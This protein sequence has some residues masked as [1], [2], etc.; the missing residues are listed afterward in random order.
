MSASRPRE[1]TAVMV[2]GN[3]KQSLRLAP[4]IAQPTGMPLRSVA[5]DHFQPHLPRSRRC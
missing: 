3:S 1:A 4:A 2:G 5:I